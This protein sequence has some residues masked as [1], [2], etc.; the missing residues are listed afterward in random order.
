MNKITLK[1]FFSNAARLGIHVKTKRQLNTL[2]KAFDK[3]NK[4]WSIDERYVKYDENYDACIRELPSLCI[5]NKGCYD[6]INYYNKM[7]FG[8]YE[9][10]EIDI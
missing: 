3:L 4:K 9:F 7:E 2:L 6:S 8:V 1:E 10:E 5:D